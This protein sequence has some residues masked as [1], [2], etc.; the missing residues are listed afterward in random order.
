MKQE[1]I[2]GVAAIVHHFGKTCPMLTSLTE[3]V[4]ERKIKRCDQLGKLDYAGTK[5][6][7]V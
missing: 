3:Q 4:L 5:N 1:H 2:I 7:I 6:T